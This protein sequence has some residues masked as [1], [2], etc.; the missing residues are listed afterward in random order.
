MAL[1]SAEVNDG[2][3]SQLGMRELY[4]PVLCFI[5]LQSG[6]LGSDIY[7]Q[8]PGIEYCP[9]PSIAAVSNIFT[10]FV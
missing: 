9:K 8:L 5:Q 1:L 10:Y 4:C 3:V 2:N 6:L 7:T